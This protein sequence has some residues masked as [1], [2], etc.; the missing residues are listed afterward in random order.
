MQEE[1]VV[2]EQTKTGKE[3]EKKETVMQGAPGG[4]MTQVR[5]NI[6]GEQKKS[7]MLHPLPFT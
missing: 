3:K 1:V 6:R 4:G 7:R 5:E 2:K